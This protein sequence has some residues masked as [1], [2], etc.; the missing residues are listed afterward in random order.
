MLDPKRINEFVQKII[1]DLPDGVKAMPEEFQHHLKTTM[2]AAL[3]KLDLVTRDE[4]DTQTQVL[5]KTREKLEQLQKQLDTL[6]DNK[7][8]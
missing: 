1:D 6:D 8:A 2:Q 5:K 3:S 7:K 4:F